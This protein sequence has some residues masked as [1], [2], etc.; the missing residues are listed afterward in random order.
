MA[1]LR[2]G[3]RVVAPFDRLRAGTLRVRR[4]GGVAR[5]DSA[6]GEIDARV[7][8]EPGGTTPCVHNPSL[9]KLW[10]EILPSFYIFP[11]INRVTLI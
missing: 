7:E 3:I 10:V 4:G 5:I 6:R 11:S 9:N 2:E 1:A 8:A